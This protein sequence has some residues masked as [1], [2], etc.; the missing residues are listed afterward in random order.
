MRIKS[1]GHGGR[2]ELFSSMHNLF[3]DRLMPAMYSIKITDAENRRA[4]AGGNFIEMAEDAHVLDL[5]LQ[6]QSIMREAHMFGKRLVSL[7]VS[8]V[9]RHVSEEGAFGFKA[10]NQLQ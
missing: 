1:D 2:P 10:L 7:L 5:K 8:E 6:L 4:Q 9:V 3:Q